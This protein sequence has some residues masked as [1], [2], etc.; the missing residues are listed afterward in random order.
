MT[1]K[2]VPQLFRER[3]V[4]M[5]ALL[6]DYDGTLVEVNE[7]KFTKEYFVQLKAFAENRMSFSGKE[8]MECIEQITNFADGKANNYERFLEC[9]SK[10]SQLNFA[11]LKGIFDTFYRSKYFENLS[12]FVKPNISVVNLVNRAKEHGILTVLATNPVFPK[13]AIIKRLEWIG[14]TECSFDLITH[15]ENSYYCKPDPRYFQQIISILKVAP[16]DCTM[17]GNDEYFDRSCEKIGIE[18]INVKEIDKI[19]LGGGEHGNTDVE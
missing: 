1:G 14:M 15:M 10:K 6:V 18:F 13:I 8:I 3:R 11:D 9:F 4:L 19:Q 7:E 2:I 16:G 12:V 5:R 17:V